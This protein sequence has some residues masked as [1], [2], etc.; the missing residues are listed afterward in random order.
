MGVLL[1]RVA[2]GTINDQ[3]KIELS[4]ASGQSGMITD[5]NYLN[6]AKFQTSE[7]EDAGHTGVTGNIQQGS[8]VS[9]DAD[10]SAQQYTLGSV[11][12]L[13]NPLPLTSIYLD[14]E[15]LSG[16]PLFIWSI[17]TDEKMVYFNLYEKENNQSV[18]VARINAIEGQSKYSWADNEKMTTGKHFFMVSMVDF[19]GHEYFGLTGPY[20]QHD[21]S[22]RLSFA[23]SGF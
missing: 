19:A 22:V 23:T 2:D 13:E 1:S 14:I 16:K 15:E 7:W 21:A 3:A 9:G 4:F 11:L 20:N 10:F 17:E 6:V 8:V 18:L 5:P 12:N